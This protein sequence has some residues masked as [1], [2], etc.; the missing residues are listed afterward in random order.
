MR[1][2]DLARMAAVA[3]PRPEA[4]PVITA[5]RPSF[6]I[7]SSSFSD[8][9]GDLAWG[10]TSRNSIAWNNPEVHSA[11]AGAIARASACQGLAFSP[12]WS[13]QTRNAVAETVNIVAK[14]AERIFA[15]LADAQTINR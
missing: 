5:H 1:A 9:S 6:D 15:D 11:S 8:V 14:T 4:E 13:Q 2:P 3:A 7:A 12:S 10:R